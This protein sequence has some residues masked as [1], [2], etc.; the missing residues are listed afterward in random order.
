[1]AEFS[2]EGAPLDAGAID[3]FEQ[4]VGVILPAD[5][6]AFLRAH[7]G[8]LVTPSA[9]H[10]ERTGLIKQFL[11]IGPPFD[12]VKCWETFKHPEHPRM[13]HDNIPIARCQGG[14]LLTMVTDGPS[15][16]HI[17]HWDHEDEDEDG[18][19]NVN[20]TFVAGSLNDLIAMLAP[21][22]MD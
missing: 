11:S 1:L 2:D 18:P 22:D 15:Q 13:P 8:G 21:L 17:F 19:S 4:S 3:A 5:Y 6:R 7:N 9:F 14:D 20:L 10:G 16:G 12:A